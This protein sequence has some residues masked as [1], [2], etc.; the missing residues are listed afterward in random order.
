MKLVRWT[1]EDGYTRQ[2]LT[3]STSTDEQ[4]IQFGIPLDPPSLA[5]FSIPEAVKKDIHNELIARDLVSWADVLAQ[6]S[7]VTALVGVV[8]R[9]HQLNR[10]EARQL[11]RDLLSAFR[12]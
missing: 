7:G 5:E 1:D 10:W 6:Q 11:R 9:R 2:V 3:R 4:A 8:A 12:R